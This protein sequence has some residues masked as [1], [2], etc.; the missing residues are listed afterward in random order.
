MALTFGLII[1]TKLNC[2]HWGVA[3]NSDPPAS[4]SVA[5]REYRYST[6]TGSLDPSFTPID[7]VDEHAIYAP[8]PPEVTSAVP[9]V[10]EYQS[11]DGKVYRYVLVG[12]P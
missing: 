8:P 11:G 10:V 3:C 7:T 1:H 12:G 5:G 2:D 4:I 6:T 9:T